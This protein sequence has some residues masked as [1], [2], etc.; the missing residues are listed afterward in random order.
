MIT[1]GRFRRRA[2]ELPSGLD[3]ESVAL[4]TGDVAVMR[5]ALRPAGFPWC[6]RR[7]SIFG[8]CFGFGASTWGVASSNMV[9]APDF[10]SCTDFVGDMHVQCCGCAFPFSLLVFSKTTHTQSG[11]YDI[12]SNKTRGP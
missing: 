7:K 11:C 10:S 5:G 8:T 3:C 1:P 4:A 9:D 6:T 2:G 12:I